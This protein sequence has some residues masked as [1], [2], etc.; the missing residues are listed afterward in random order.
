MSDIQE[1]INLVNEHGFYPDSIVADGILKRFKRTPQDKHPDAWCRVFENHTSSGEKFYFYL[2]GDWREPGLEIKVHSK[3]KL[4]TI[5]KKIIEV[6]I[7]ETRKEIERERNSLKEKCIKECEQILSSAQEFVETPYTIKKKIKG[8]FKAKTKLQ[9]SERMLLVPVKTIDDKLVGLQKIYPNGRKFFHP[10]TAKKGAFHLIGD[11]INGEAYICEGFATGA[12][13]HMATGKPVAVAFDAGN[14][15][16]VAKEIR[17]KYKETKITICGDDDKWTESNPG[18]KYAIEAAAI[19]NGEVIFPEFEEPKEGLTDFNDLHIEEGLDKVKETL[20]KLPMKID[21]NDLQ[22]DQNDKKTQQKRSEMSVVEELLDIF[23]QNMVKKDE[24]FFVYKNGVWKHLSDNELDLIKV[25]ALELFGE[26]AKSSDAESAFR[27]FIYHLQIAK[28]DMFQPNPYCVNFLNG[29]LHI[30]K[31]KE[32][33][34]EKKFLP[35]NREDYLINQL[36]Y[37]YEENNHDQNKEFLDMIDRLFS[38]DPDK[39]EKIMAIKQM[40]GACLAPAFPHLF[41]LHGKEQSGKTTLILIAQKLLK[42]ENISSIEPYEFKGFSMASMAGKLANI[43]TDIDTDKPIAD[44][45]IKKIE[46]RI[47]VA[48]DRKFKTLLYAPLPAIHIFAGNGIPPT[49]DGSSKAHARRWTFI[50]FKS[51]R[52]TGNYDKSYPDWVFNQSPR[53]ILNFALE[54][55]DLLLVARGHFINPESGKERLGEWMNDADLTQQFLDAIDHLEVK[56]KGGYTVFKDDRGEINQVDLYG[57][58]LVF[59]DSHGYVRKG[60]GITARKFYAAL[61]SKNIPFGRNKEARVF[62][63]FSVKMT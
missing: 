6:Q 12:S 17:R 22:N 5:D 58:F 35:H 37:D 14:L 54:G 7:E 20:N 21:P 30:F 44:A 39:K 3:K 42:A 63:G 19:A 48:M 36:P 59:S 1:I 9:G 50:E 4:S 25:K 53:G 52:A 43:V 15:V 57:A 29:T 26:K 13:L 33:D 31:N 8:D 24:D 55:L 61:R 2:G 16:S 38:D 10:G 41:M 62:Y 49:L 45:N 28:K 47:P 34:W 27:S 56:T 51:F 40:Y 11:H 46:D 32:Q 60:D 23:G 18:R